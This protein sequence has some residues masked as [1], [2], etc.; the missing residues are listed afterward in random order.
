MQIFSI[1][2]SSDEVF[3]SEDDVSDESSKLLSASFGEVSSDCEEEEEPLSDDEA[4]EAEFDTLLDDTDLASGDACAD[5]SSTCFLYT[6][7]GSA[8]D[9]ITSPFA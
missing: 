8:S 2:Y 4:D 7:E 3:S 6:L 1:F 9:F 5:V